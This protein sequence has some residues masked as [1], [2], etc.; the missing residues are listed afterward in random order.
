MMSDQPDK[1]EPMEPKREPMSKM[2]KAIARMT[3][4]SV[5]TAPHFYSQIEIDMQRAQDTVTELRARYPDVKVS[6]L[7]LLIKV[8]A[9]TLQEHP[10]L[11]ASL[12]G[13][14]IVYNNEVNIGVV[15][16]LEDGMLIPVVRAAEKA[17]LV[18]LAA[19]TAGLIDRA[20][21]Q[22]SGAEDLLNGTFTLSNLG[23]V[24]PDSFTSIIRS[25]QS[26][27]LSLGTVADRPFVRSGQ[28]V[29]APTMIATL[30]VD[31]RVID[32]AHAAGFLLT[33]KRILE[34]P[35]LTALCD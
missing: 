8:C 35:E 4:L 3:T 23:K 21:R 34:T 30:G 28:L 11:N 9:A 32:G 20:R 14:T 18:D 2:R 13:E 19:Q 29:V 5:Q 22:R 31:H 26:A 1:V 24:G 12:D 10:R 16:A 6:L 27:I 33:F 25:P 15:V 17:R 7:H